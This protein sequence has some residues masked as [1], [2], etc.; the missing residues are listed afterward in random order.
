MTKHEK[1]QL[2]AE[3]LFQ[4]IWKLLPGGFPLQNVL[5]STVSELKYSE[6]Q[7]NDAIEVCSKAR[8]L[9]YEIVDERLWETAMNFY[10]GLKDLWDEGAERKTLRIAKKTSLSIN[11]GPTGPVVAQLE[12]IERRLK[13]AG[14]DD[15][16]DASLDMSLYIYF[17]LLLLWLHRH[18]EESLLND[19]LS[20]MTS[21]ESHD[22]AV[23]SESPVSPSKSDVFKFHCVHCGQR[24]SSRVDRVGT[25][26]NCPTCG[27]ELQVP[28]MDFPEKRIEAAEIDLDF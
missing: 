9:T 2:L 16:F 14:G 1:Q 17:A 5:E 24:I 4:K 25:M 26:S 28:K 8:S 18:G 27:K 3:V 12:E 23:N 21:T 6:K 20:C 7:L 22:D 13:G 11:S 19:V 10:D 15:S